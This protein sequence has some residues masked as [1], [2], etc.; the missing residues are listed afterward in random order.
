MHQLIAP[1]SL[2]HLTKVAR[3]LFIPCTRAQKCH[4]PMH[5]S[6]HHNVVMEQ[7]LQHSVSN[8]FMTELHVVQASSGGTLTGS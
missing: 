3:D 2:C 8:S 6:K 5:L 7:A 1:V 4:A